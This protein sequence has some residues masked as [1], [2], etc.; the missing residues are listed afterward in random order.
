[1]PTA[2]ITGMWK[3]VPEDPETQMEAT[4][5]PYD[6]FFLRTFAVSSDSA[7]AHTWASTVVRRYLGMGDKRALHIIRLTISLEGP[8]QGNIVSHSVGLKALRPCESLRGTLK[9]LTIKEIWRFVL[10]EIM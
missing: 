2:I 3:K 9:M 5:E 6:D 8:L 4:E 10:F 7:C 1:M